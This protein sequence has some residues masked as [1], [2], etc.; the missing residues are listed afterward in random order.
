[1]N[2]PPPEDVASLRSVLD[3]GEVADHLERVAPE[4]FKAVSDFWRVSTEGP[5]LEA[6]VK[7]LVL[8]AMHA[9]AT[10]LDVAAMKRHI[11]RA[12]RAGA[13]DA[14]IV[15]VLVTVIP[16]ANHAVYVSIPIVD[17]EFAAASPDSEGP[18]H[19]VPD[20]AF[21]RAK[22]EFIA[23]RG[24]WN[25]DRERLARLIPGYLDALTALSTETWNNGTLT[26]KERA[27]VCIGIDSMI[28]HSYE[29]GLRRHVRNA[30]AA[31]ASRGE[32]LEVLQLTGVLGLEGYLLGAQMLFDARDVQPTST[33]ARQ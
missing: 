25:P 9:A 17:E 24:F 30:I 6:R 31:G 1:M 3:N 14:E 19:W 16:L 15:D 8:I 29:P 5:F 13:S 22:A 12:K 33:D 28:T 18:D 26:P 10:S 21:E 32:V 23:S 7:E 27:L 4:T 20:E 11:V 2:N